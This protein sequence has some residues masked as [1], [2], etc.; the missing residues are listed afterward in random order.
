MWRSCIRHSQYILHIGGSRVTFESQLLCGKYISMSVGS[1]GLHCL[2]YS[3]TH[4]QVQQ[5]DEHMSAECSHI[6]Q[7]LH[8]IKLIHPH[9]CHANS[10]IICSTASHMNTFMQKLNARSFQTTMNTIWSR[11][12]VAVILMLCTNVTTQSLSYCAMQLLSDIHYI[13]RHGTLKK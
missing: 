13:R 8:H 4:C 1:S 12:A 5:Q 10:Y 9:V 11:C 3:L 2:M 6:A 7:Y